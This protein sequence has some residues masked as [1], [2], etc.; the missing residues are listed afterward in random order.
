MNMSR[1]TFVQPLAG[2][3][4]V[5]LG[6]TRARAQAPIPTKPIRLIVGFAAGGATDIGRAP[7]RTGAVGAARP[8]VRHREPAGR[9]HQH[10]APKRS[11]RGAGRLHDAA[12]QPA[13]NASTR[14]STRSSTS[15]SSATSR[16]SPASVASPIVMLVNPSLPAKTFP[17]SSPTPR[18]I[19]ARSTWPSAASAPSAHLSGELFKMMTGVD[20][21]HV[22]YRGAAPALTDLIGGQVTVC[23]PGIA[24]AV[25]YVKSG[26][27]RALGRDDAKRSET[28]PDMPTVAEFV[29]GYEASDVVRHR[30]ARRTR[31]PRSSTS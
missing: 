24:V 2:A 17:S 16:R 14:R 8:A 26:R 22:P 13:R 29:P 21:L 20:M 30:R 12:R 1:R 28:L 15:I 3:G 4:L 5:P 27:L 31:P 6:A 19:R 10:R 23:S 25:G 7:D 9:R 18:P 11:S